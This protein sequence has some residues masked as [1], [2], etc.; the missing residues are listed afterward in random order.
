[1][2]ICQNIFMIQEMTYEYG[3]LL[4]RVFLYWE[5]LFYC[6]FWCF[7]FLSI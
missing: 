3:A 7:T 1:M 6:F 2:W 5:H 4:F